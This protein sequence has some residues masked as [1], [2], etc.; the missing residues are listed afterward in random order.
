MGNALFVLERASNKYVIYLGESDFME[1][2]HLMT[3]KDKIKS[4]NELS[5][6]IP[7]NYAINTLG[8]RISEGSE[9]N[10]SN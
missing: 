6:V 10:K 5:C 1:L 4:W 8:V 2:N 9:P 3:V 7:N